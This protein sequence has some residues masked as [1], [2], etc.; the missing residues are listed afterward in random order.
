VGEYANDETVEAYFQLGTA[1][2]EWEEQ[3]TDIPS[4]WNRCRRKQLFLR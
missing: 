2:T 3:P 1:A 4:T